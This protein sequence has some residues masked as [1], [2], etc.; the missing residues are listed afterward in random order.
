LNPSRP[1]RGVNQ[2]NRSQ[3]GHDVNKLKIIAAF[4]AYVAAL[5][6]AYA[7]VISP[8]YSYLGYRL[9]WPEPMRFAAIVLFCLA[10]C[11]FIPAR[12]ERPSVLV[13]W[14]LYATVYIP[15]ILLPALTLTMSATDLLPLDLAML[16]CLG[17][18]TLLS[19]RAVFSVR[20]LSISP[21]YFWP[22]VFLAGGGCLLFICTQF[23][24]STLVFNIASLFVGGNEYTIRHGFFDQLSE[25]GRILGYASGQVGEAIDP[26]LIAYGLVYRRRKF[27]ALGIAGQL[28]LFAV[29]GN[30]SILFST[31]FPAIVFFLVRRFPRNFG[32]A[33]GSLLVAVVLLSTAGDVLSNGIAFS[34]LT[35][36]RTLMDPGLLTGFYYEHYS[37]VPHAG[38]AYHF[39]REGEA[40]LGPSHEIGLVYFGSARID[41]NANLWAEGFADFGI[42]GI[43]GFTFLLSA[44]LWMFDLVA[45]R[46]N[47][48]LA[49][50]IMAMQAFFF[51]NSAPLTVFITHGGLCSALLLWSAP[52]PEPSGAELEDSL[53]E[54]GGE[55]GYVLSAS[56]AGHG[57]AMQAW[58]AE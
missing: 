24:L 39:P 21:E 25:T 14:W 10:P 52:S 33:L 1:F 13:L 15:S 56:V 49:I 22:V 57:S 9:N 12:L 8:I 32:A 50:L 30:K 58:N 47:A 27:L 51:S 38:L 19:S 34:N 46:Q 53:S 4:A 16:V 45:A 37:L 26:F 48:E 43:F 28:I 42:A 35:T 44:I 20:H 41:A 23:R 5:L 31:L 11:A 6:W 54:D 18:M 36:R 55:A 17:L 40:I 29:A 2:S 7:V 3:P